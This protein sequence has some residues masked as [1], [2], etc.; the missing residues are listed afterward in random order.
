MVANLGIIV[1]AGG[2]QVV[3]TRSRQ[4]LQENFEHCSM[5]CPVC[6]E[7]M[8]VA[9][10]IALVET[11]MQRLPMLLETLRDVLVRKDE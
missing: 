6:G 7:Q 1:T 11:A 8:K 2:V 5:T 3:S 4:V 9:D 10:V